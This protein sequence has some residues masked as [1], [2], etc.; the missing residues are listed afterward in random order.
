MSVVHHY[1]YLPSSFYGSVVP[2]QG[3]PGIT[4]SAHQ[5]VVFFLVS[6]P[7]PRKV[8]WEAP[9]RH[10]IGLP[11]HLQQLCS[12]DGQLVEDVVCEEEIFGADF[13]DARDSLPADAA[14]PRCDVVDDGARLVASQD[15]QRRDRQVARVFP[16]EPSRPGPIQ[17]S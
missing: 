3:Y 8:V 10:P 9:P 5:R 12:E 17:P 16:S 15:D 2:F 7:P 14:E 1:K 6:T 13:F 11:R 4:N